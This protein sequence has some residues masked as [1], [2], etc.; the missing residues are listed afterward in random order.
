MTSGAGTRVAIHGLFITALLLIG[1]AWELPVLLVV[2]LVLMA[3]EW[4]LGRL[5]H[6][7][8]TA[9]HAAARRPLTDVGQATA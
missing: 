3:A 7:R 1:A 6:A 2:A 4:P 9:A 8:H 5:V